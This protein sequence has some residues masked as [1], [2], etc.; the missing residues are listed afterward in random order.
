MINELKE[1]NSAEGGCIRKYSTESAY[2]SVLIPTPNVSRIG[3]TTK[4]APKETVGDISITI[5]W[6]QRSNSS[7]LHDDN[8]AISNLISSINDQNSFTYTLK[9]VVYYNSTKYYLWELVDCGSYSDDEEFYYENKRW[10]LTEDNWFECTTQNTMYSYEVTFL[11]EDL[12]SFYTMGQELT[13]DVSQWYQTPNT[14]VYVIKL[15]YNES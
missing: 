9:D 13:E 10:L 1:K 15:Q 6:A 8:S 7:I 14:L 12:D 11:S 3:R 5:D 2:N 4:Y